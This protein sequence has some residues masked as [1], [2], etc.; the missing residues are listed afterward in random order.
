MSLLALAFLTG[1]ENAFSP[2]AL[3]LLAFLW[4][5]TDAGLARRSLPLM[6]G[7]GIAY[8][9]LTAS[10]SGGYSM[11]VVWVRATA[12]LVLAAVAMRSFDRACRGG[13]PSLA[14]V[15]RPGAR[16]LGG[17]AWALLLG[18]CLGATYTPYV[19]PA[20]SWLQAGA[21]SAATSVLQ[22]LVL[23]LAVSGAL[24]G[25]RALFLRFS[26]GGPPDV[27][28]LRVM[29][30]IAA[31]G[32]VVILASGSART[33]LLPIA[34]AEAEAVDARLLSAS[35][36]GPALNS[37]R[38][39]P[40]SAFGAS[41]PWINSA[42]LTPA[43]LNGHVVLVDFWTYSCIN[44]LRALPEIRALADRYG[45]KGLIVIGVHSPEF[46]FEHDEAKV[47]AAVE[48]LHVAYPVV[49]DNSWRLWNAFNNQF[50]PAQYLID[51]GGR[52]RYRHYGEQGGAETEAMARALL[53]EGGAG[54]LPAAQGDQ[55]LR[56]GVAA[57]ASV[58]PQRSP[59]T[60]LGY[61][62]ADSH[63]LGAA[64]HDA[65]EDYSSA[66]VAHR[67]EWGLDGNWVQGAQS[68]RLVT[69]GGRIVYRFLAR[70]LHLVLGPAADGRPI[71]FRVT[72]DGHAPAADH[73]GDTSA[74]GQGVVREHRLYQLVRQGDG[75]AERRFEIE[76][77]DP[78]V[79]A[80]AFT[81]G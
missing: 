44:C 27:A 26:R 6:L 9:L 31:L 45:K 65:P 25:L 63:A 38:P 23:G 37:A 79:E 69:A 70:D 64:R 58:S 2:S 40:L 68:V 60:Y 28:A 47:R 33:F 71:R 62:R 5:G 51:S 54:A 14:N 76:F 41:G 17:G 21:A 73:G 52:I 29:H 49:M 39:A 24:I 50:W 35:G 10:A 16:V 74:D 67:D 3:P 78:G 11:I 59:E 42:P 48:R 55:V 57:P 1:I 61:A 80:F 12:V 66:R 32:A 34:R 18:G 8:A 22:L 4:V 53:V 77:L 72:L 7:F 30:A 56:E 15:L 36:A 19:G 46:A 75:T 81:F 20:L 13:A 43:A